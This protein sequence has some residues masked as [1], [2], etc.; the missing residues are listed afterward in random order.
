MALIRCP[1][2]SRTGGRITGKDG[3]LF[4]HVFNWPED[5]LLAFNVLETN[6]IGRACLLHDKRQTELE[7]RPASKGEVVINLS[8]HLPFSKSASVIALDMR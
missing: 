6:Q 7:I 3:R 1:N 2:L 4:L 8:G 5:H